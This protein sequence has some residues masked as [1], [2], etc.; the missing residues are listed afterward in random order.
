MGTANPGPVRYAAITGVEDNLSRTAPDPRR[1]LSLSVSVELPGARPAL[2]LVKERPRRW[3]Q[4]RAGRIVAVRAHSSIPDVVTYA[5]D[6]T[7]E[8]Q[9]AGL[10]AQRAA[11]G[12]LPD[13]ASADDDLVAATL[14]AVHAGTHTLGEHTEMLFDVEVSRPDTAPEHHLA[15]GFHLPEEIAGHRQGTAVRI[16]PGSPAILWPDLELVTLSAQHG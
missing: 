1:T 2:L 11:H 12:L 3:S 7:R 4:L 8:Q 16:R 6:L 14:R 5:G 15:R 9:L 10:V 13:L